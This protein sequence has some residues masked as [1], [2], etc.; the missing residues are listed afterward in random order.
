MAFLSSR[1]KETEAKVLVPFAGARVECGGLMDVETGGVSGLE[2]KLVCS[3]KLQRLWSGV[4]PGSLC[5][6]LC[7]C[8]FKCQPTALLCTL[9]S[10]QGR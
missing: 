6:T 1:I 7:V 4:E 3:F 10:A 8:V 5:M 2:D 9:G